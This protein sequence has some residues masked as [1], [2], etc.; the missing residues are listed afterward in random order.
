MAHV[1]GP[2]RVPCTS[3]I[4]PTLLGF[5][6]IQW[7]LFTLAERGEEK[8]AAA[9]PGIRQCAA[10]IQPP[11]LL[12]RRRFEAPA[13][14]Q[15]PTFAPRIRP[16]DWISAPPIHPS[17]WTSTRRFAPPTSAP[18]DSGLLPLLRLPAS[19][20]HVGHKYTLLSP[21]L[22]FLHVLPLL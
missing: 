10:S 13:A 7:R 1:L 6:G 3:T 2:S 12:P 11:L 4:L 14:P 9:A 8:R 18:I 21:P 15:P 17:D 5:G 16:S 22:L 19:I 20:L